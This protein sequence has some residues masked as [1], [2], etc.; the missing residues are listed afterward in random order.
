MPNAWRAGFPRHRSRARP[1]KSR[2]P[3][4]DLF[5]IRRSQTTEVGPMRGPPFA[6]LS[7]FAGYLK[8]GDKYRNGVMKHPHLI[9]PYPN[10]KVKSTRFIKKNANFVLIK[11]LTKNRTFIKIPPVARALTRAQHKK[12]LSRRQTN[13][14]E[15]HRHHQFTASRGTLP[16]SG[17]PPRSY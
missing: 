5:V 11:N 2:S 7:V 15:N 13:E 3:D 1:C 14:P 6:F 16:P 17:F 8:G 9:I 4:P 12:T 10:P